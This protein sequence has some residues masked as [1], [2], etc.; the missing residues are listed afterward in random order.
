MI[1]HLVAF[2]LF[3]ASFAMANHAARQGLETIRVAI[4]RKLVDFAPFFFGIKTGVYRSEGLEPQL[5]VTRSSIIPALISGELDYATRYQSALR[6]AL[7]GVPARVIATR[8]TKQSNFL[9]SQRDIRRV[10]ISKA[11]ASQSQGLPVRQTAARERRSIRMGS[12]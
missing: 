5:I 12:T 11:G 9:F 7:S 1:L 10:R 3:I 2:A 6:R 8:I 4:P